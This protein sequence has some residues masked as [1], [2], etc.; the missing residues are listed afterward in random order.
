M[1][2]LYFTG[3]SSSLPTT[4]QKVQNGIL[5]NSNCASRMPASL[6]NAIGAY[7]IC[8][9]D[10]AGDSGACNVRLNCTEYKTNSLTIT[11]FLLQGDSGGPMHC[12]EGGQTVVAGVTSW[13]ISSFG[14]CQTSYPSVYTRVS[15]FR[16]W[17]SN[18]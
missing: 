8:I 14:N 1:V 13:G 17:I 4:L 16:D 2:F 3:S 9:Y 7:H 11:P 12:T 15:Y 10:S 5:S 6:R 18:N